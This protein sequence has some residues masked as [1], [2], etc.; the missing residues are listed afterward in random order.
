MPAQTRLCNSGPLGDSTSPRADFVLDRTNCKRKV[1][2]VN[3]VSYDM[4]VPLS[5]A[6]L[7]VGFLLVGCAGVVT[8][9]ASLQDQGYQPLVLISN[10]P[11]GGLWWK[12]TRDPQRRAHFCLVPAWDMTN[13]GYQWAMAL[14]IDGKETWTYESGSFGPQPTLRMGIDCTTTGPLPEGHLTVRLTRVQYWQ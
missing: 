6:S 12:E 13:R 7:L 2:K 5:V 1:K 10:M 11:G 14:D 3:Y 9:V 4:K 8:N